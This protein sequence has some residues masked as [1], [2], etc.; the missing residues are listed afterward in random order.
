MKYKKLII[1]DL[2]KD[3]NI[4]YDNVLYVYL[5]KG[6]INFKNSQRL[7]LESIRKKKFY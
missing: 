3:S 4:H 6:K 7:Y 2:N 1:V 5:N